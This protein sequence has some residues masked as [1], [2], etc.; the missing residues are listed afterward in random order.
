MKVKTKRKKRCASS[1]SLK[2]FG[3][4]FTKSEW[5]KK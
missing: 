4:A 2:R 5:I 3:P 1:F